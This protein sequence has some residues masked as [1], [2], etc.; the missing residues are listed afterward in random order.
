MIICFLWFILG[1]ITT[2]NFDVGIS[3]RCC[4]MFPW[5]CPYL[6]LCHP[7]H[8]FKCV[9]VF[10]GIECITLHISLPPKNKK[11]Q[12][13]VRFCNCWRK[14]ISCGLVLTDFCSGRSHKIF[15]FSIS[16]WPSWSR[17]EFKSSFMLPS[18]WV[19]LV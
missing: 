11:N 12:N 5:T 16:S 2:Y 6:D 10:F 4:D 18:K 17:H 15:T 9:G 8:I 19:A 13:S 7:N 1:C 14:F 3:S